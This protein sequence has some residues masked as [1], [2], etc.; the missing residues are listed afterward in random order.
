MQKFLL[1]GV[2]SICLCVTV[3]ASGAAARRLGESPEV[4]DAM[5]RFKGRVGARLPDNPVE[6]GEYFLLLSAQLRSVGLVLSSG[7]VL[8]GR[9]HDYVCQMPSKIED[10]LRK[11]GIRPTRK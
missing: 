5:T 8:D 7:H 2:S 6:V 10:S 11:A 9:D 3:G 1:I 4:A